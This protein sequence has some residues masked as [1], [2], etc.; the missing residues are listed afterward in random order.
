MK[1]L[2][3]TLA[4]IFPLVG[5]AQD[6]QDFKTGTFRLKDEAGNYVPNYSIVRKKNLQIETIGENYIKTKVVWIDDCTSELI[7]IKSDIL[8]VPKGTVTRVK[9]TSTFEGG[10]KGA[11]TSEVTEGIVNFTM[12]KVD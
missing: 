6:C 3:F 8:D 1:K 5:I 12:Y 9:I 2:L 4:L 10:Y 7:L 11:G